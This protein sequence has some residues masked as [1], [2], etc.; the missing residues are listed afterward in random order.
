M[1]IDRE[2]RI[3]DAVRPSRANEDGVRIG[4]VNNMPD[5]ALAQTEHQFRDVLRRAVP[6]LSIS[7]QLYALPGIPRGEAG[8]HHLL[9]NGYRDF[10]AADEPTLDGVIV[11]GTEP[12]AAD[13]REERYWPWLAELFDWIAV[14]GPPAIFS[15]LAA[16]AAVLHYDGI[17]R[18]RLPEKRFGL[19]DHVT[20]EQH[21]LTQ[22]LPPSV[23]VAHSRWNDVSARALNDSGYQILTQS[24]EAGVDVF[25]KTMRNPLIFFQGHPEY[26]SH[27]L[28]REYRRDV[29]RFLRGERD[30]YPALPHGYFGD[31]ER[32]VLERFQAHAL[33]SRSE[34]LMAS[35]PLAGA[36]FIPGDTW[37]GPAVQLMRAWLKQIAAKRADELKRRPKRRER[38]V[39]ILN[40]RGA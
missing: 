24:P 27:A 17:A 29:R 22:F 6:G 32:C 10:L 4:L 13:L 8:L 35:F 19:F 33:E 31:E 2:D 11:T 40:E 12:T 26:D 36:Q 21:A 3:F 39:Q 18:E 16:H 28:Y 34:Q 5:R 30:H 7:L 38:W 25:V 14:Q 15:C 20:I 9:V 1:A 37:Q 23:K